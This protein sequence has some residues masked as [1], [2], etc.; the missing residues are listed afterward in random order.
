MADRTGPRAQGHFVAKPSQKYVSGLKSAPLGLQK[1]P[2]WNRNRTGMEPEW[3]QN[4]T[5]MEPKGNRKEPK[6]NRN[7]TEIAKW[8]QNGTEMLEY[9][10]FCQTPCL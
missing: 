5:G 9:T 8:S 7:G 3:N 6:W 1:E 4:G 10:E 2:K